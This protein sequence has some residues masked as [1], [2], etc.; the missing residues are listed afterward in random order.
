[1]STTQLFTSS[2]RQQG[3]GLTLLRLVTGVIFAAHG[4]Q[5]LFIYGIE[6]VQG[7]F[8]K[9]GAPLPLITGPMVAG[10]EFFGGLALIVGFLTRIVSLGLIATM[11]GAMVLV[12]FANGF[13]MPTGYEFVLML[14]VAA[15]ALFFGGAGRFSIDETIAHRRAAHV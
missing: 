14:M 9:M 12:H 5:K 10:L 3:L 13:F 8:T 1:M 7:A 6:G 11:L 4:Y 2:P 15:L